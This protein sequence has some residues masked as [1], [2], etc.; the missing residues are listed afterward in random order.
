MAWL[1]GLVCT[2]T[3]AAQALRQVLVLVRPGGQASLEQCLVAMYTRVM[4]H[5]HQE[6]P[7]AL[8]D[9]NSVLLALY[10]QAEGGAGKAT[11]SDGVGAY[12]HQALPLLQDPRNLKGPAPG[13]PRA[14]CLHHLH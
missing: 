7:T 11:S 14:L 10:L 5:G 13:S 12:L 1:R 6:G 8:G 4:G 9:L 3:P 2:A